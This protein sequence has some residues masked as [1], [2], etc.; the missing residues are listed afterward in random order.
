MTEALKDKLTS[1]EGKKLYGYQAKAID[2]IM[3]RMR[4]FPE[5]YNVLYQLPT[6]GGKTVIFSE[7][8]K[9]FILEQGKKV[10]ILTHRIELLGQTSRMLSD[11]GVDNKIIDSKVKMLEEDKE[12]WCYVAMVETLNNRLN[13]EHIAFDNLGLVVIDEAHY[14][15]FRKLFKFFENQILLGVTATPLSSNIKLPLKDNYQELIVGESISKLV[16]EGYLAKAMTYS[17]DVNLKSLKVG[18]NGDYTVSSSERLYGNYFMQEK[19]L[20]AYEE[21]A[22]GKKTLIFNNGIHTSLM[23]AQLFEEE[24]YEIRHL[25]NT[26]TEKERQE[27]LTWF[28]EKPDAILTSVSILTTGFDEPS[29]ET[30]ILNRATKSLTLYHQM[31]GRGSRVFNEKKDFTVI[32]LGN[33]ARRFG[34]WNAHVNWEDIFRAPNAYLEGLYTDEEIEETFVYDMPERLRVLFRVEEMEPFSMKD[35]YVEAT[36]KGKRPKEA[37]NFSLDNHVEMIKRVAEDEFHAI[38]L[39]DELDGDIEQRIRDY[40]KCISKTTDNYRQWLIEEYLRK[41]KQGLRLAFED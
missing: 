40:T 20:Y 30:I 27:I 7:L 35:A 31:I 2:T 37:I 32:D 19:L 41:L 34:L 14:N 39:I 18:I 29:V 23:V 28:H 10:L 12:H 15:S 25:D 11:I 16:E 38:E 22:K 5:N 3:D 17:Y 1:T 13:D 26:H 21:K 6:G 24:G 8:A 9:R 33:N 36:R 4:R